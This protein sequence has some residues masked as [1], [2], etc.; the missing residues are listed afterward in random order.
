MEAIW[1]NLIRMEA[2]FQW[3]KLIRMLIT[4]QVITENPSLHSQT[5]SNSRI[6]TIQ[7]TTSKNTLL[8]EAPTTI[9]T[10]D[11][12]LNNSTQTYPTTKKQ[13]RNTLSNRTNPYSLVIHSHTK[14]FN[15]FP[16]SMIN[17]CSWFYRNSRIFWNIMSST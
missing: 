14:A 7:D 10:I 13:N 12:P 11:H 8:Q 17:T 5:I 16:K 2:I 1:I 4:T 3:K 9:Q 6:I 15:K